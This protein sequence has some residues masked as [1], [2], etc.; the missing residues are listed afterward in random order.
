MGQK[1]LWGV[2][3][4]PPPLP[5]GPGNGPLARETQSLT[6]SVDNAHQTRLQTARNLPGYIPANG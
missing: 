5:L 1:V 3:L 6:L 4:P 2:C